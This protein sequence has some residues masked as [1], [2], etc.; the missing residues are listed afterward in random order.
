MWYQSRS[1]LDLISK[2]GLYYYI[3]DRGNPVVRMHSSF[4]LECESDDTAFTE[5]VKRTGNWEAWN[6]VAM[7]NE[8]KTPLSVFIDVGANVGYYSI[9]A[10]TSGVGVCA[11]EP[12]PDLIEFINRS[13]DLNNIATI[14]VH[15][16]A[17]GEKKDTLKLY[18]HVGH[19]GANSL[20]GEGDDFIE[21][22]VTTIDAYRWSWKEDKNRKHVIKVDV[23][24][25]ER[26]VWNGSTEFR[27]S[28]RQNVWFVEWVPVRHGEEYNREWLDEVLKTHDLQMVNHDGSLRN[29]TIDDALAVEFET[30]VFRSR[31]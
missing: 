25:F 22:E 6:A 16:L 23:E 5:P 2:A 21:T 31:S 14:G 24:G 10:A 8:W 29:V 11:F 27:Q 9:F 13:K 28:C 30:I 12:N 26:E 3:N 20:Y 19:S 17:V 18:K 7:S 4:W 1:E 15:N